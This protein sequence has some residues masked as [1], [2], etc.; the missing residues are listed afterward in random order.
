M[1]GLLLGLAVLLGSCA[2]GMDYE[3]ADS[4]QCTIWGAQPGTPDYASCRA[5]LAAKRSSDL[6]GARF[7]TGSLSAIAA[8]QSAAQVQ[9]IRTTCFKRG[10]Q[11]SGMNKI[12]YYDCMGSGHAVTQNAVS[13]CD[14]T[15]QR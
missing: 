10:E 3:A 14:L 6:A 11:I 2:T 12:C 15:V 13:L 7:A 8:Q 1:R 4:A 9:P 5:S